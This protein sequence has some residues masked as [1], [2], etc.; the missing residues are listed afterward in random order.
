MDGL[1]KDSEQLISK[2]AKDVENLATETGKDI[3]KKADKK[4]KELTEIGE[5]KI[6]TVQ[7]EL[8]KLTDGSVELGVKTVKDLEKETEKS[9]EK[10]AA[11]AKAYAFKKSTEI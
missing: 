11:D 4:K 3:E 7:G 9:I 6:E 2:T 10:A 1:K 8:K 5:K